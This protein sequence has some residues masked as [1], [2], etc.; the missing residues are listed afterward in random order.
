MNL[1]VHNGIVG[2]LIF[3]I[4]LAAPVY[5]SRRSPNS[6]LGVSVVAAYLVC[7]TFGVILSTPFAMLPIAV[8]L[9][10]MVKSNSFLIKKPVDKSVQGEMRPT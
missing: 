4:A 10:W 1:L 9:G 7:D 2:T 6:S 8:T 5:W 3:L